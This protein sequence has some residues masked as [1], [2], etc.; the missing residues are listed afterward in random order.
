MDLLNVTHT[1]VEDDVMGNTLTTFTLEKE[2][3][4]RQIS[5]GLQLVLGG[6]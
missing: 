3:V 6:L 5:S 2:Q 4:H 1:A